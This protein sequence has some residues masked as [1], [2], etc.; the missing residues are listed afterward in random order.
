MHNVNGGFLGETHTSGTR[1]ESLRKLIYSNNLSFLMEAHDALSAA[2]AERSGFKGLWASGLS[3]ASSLGYRDANEASWTQIIDVV[4]RMVDAT[5]VPILVDADSGFGNFNNARLAALKLWQRDAAGMCIEDKGFPKMNSFVGDRHPLAEIDEFCGR[6]RAVKDSVPDRNFVLVARI[7]ALIAGHG[8]EEAI[9]RAHAYSD[10]GADA[11]LIHS[12][13]SDAGEILAFAKAWQ[14]QRPLVIVPTKYYRTP[15]ACYR[16]AGISTVIW[17]NHNMRA[18]IAAMRAVCSRVLDEEGIA[19]I[20]GEVAG[21]DDVFE[22]LRYGELAEA[23]RRYLPVK[24][25]AD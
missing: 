4:E 10:A 3:I 8:A 13:K 21:L 9:E 1:T 23:E 15:T 16:D 20:E 11:I 24:G 14:N 19:S 22:L 2:V 17:A 5:T 18:A 6:L 25:K 7:E 12:R